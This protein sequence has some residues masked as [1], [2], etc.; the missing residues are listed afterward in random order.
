MKILRGT[1][2]D[3]TVI[4]RHTCLACHLFDKIIF[5]TVAE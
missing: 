2:H 1:A 3:C 4:Y 5:S